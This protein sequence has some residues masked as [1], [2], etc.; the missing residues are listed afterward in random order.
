MMKET[1]PVSF[2]ELKQSLT[3]A[4]VKIHDLNLENKRLRGEI[5]TLKKVKN[6]S[7]SGLKKEKQTLENSLLESDEALKKQKLKNS[8]LMNEIYALKKGQKAL[9]FQGGFSLMEISELKREMAFQELEPLFGE[10]IYSKILFKE[11]VQNLKH[12]EAAKRMEETIK[13]TR[14]QDLLSHFSF[15]GYN[16]SNDDKLLISDFISGLKKQKKMIS[17][18]TPELLIEVS[19]SLPPSVVLDYPKL[20][21]A[22]LCILTELYQKIKQSTPVGMTLSFE[23]KKFILTITGTKAKKEKENFFKKELFAKEKKIEDALS[24]KYAQYLISRLKGEMNVAPEEGKYHFEIALP[25]Q[26]IKM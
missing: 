18:H 3:G 14:L 23:E 6:E 25:V 8:E 15:D 12:P 22:V 9:S 21:S 10:N 5:E 24:V 19:D 17:S 4:Y 7:L 1:I 2:D 11:M 26:R 20:Y 16:S 13:E